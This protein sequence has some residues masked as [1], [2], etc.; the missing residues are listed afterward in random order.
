MPFSA[1]VR[2]GPLSPLLDCSRPLLAGTVTDRE[3]EDLVEYPLHV[4]GP[5]VDTVVLSG[6]APAYGPSG[7]EVVGVAE[8]EQGI[9]H[10]QL[11]LYSLYRAHPPLSEIVSVEMAQDCPQAMVHFRERP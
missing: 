7:W 3:G 1:T 5:G 4:W 11:H 8:E 10:V 6:S 9:W 2:P